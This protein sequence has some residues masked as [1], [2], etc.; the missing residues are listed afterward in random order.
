MTSEQKKKIDFWLEN[1]DEDW[2]TAQSMMKS[3]H[4]S[5]S[6]FVAHLAIEKLLKGIIISHNADPLMIHD[7][8]RLAKQAKIS[9]PEN[10]SEWLEE[11][12][13]FNIA[14][15]YSIEKLQF[16]KKATREYSGEWINKCK[17]V[18]KWLKKYIN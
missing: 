14:A 4:Y 8:N 5:W 13:A 1:A 17:E 10:Y 15:R 3:R 16:H 11:I 9:L 12:S 6:L 18:F 7:L 2:Q